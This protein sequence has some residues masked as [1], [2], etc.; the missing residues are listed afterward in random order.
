MKLLV[1][2]CSLSSGYGFPSTYDDSRIWPNLL[3]NK[4]GAE[5]TNVSVPGYDNTG[6]FLNAISEFTAT[7]YDLILVQFTSL[8]RIV[9]S[10]NVHSRLNISNGYPL[11]HI[12]GKKENL[13]FHKSFVMLNKG[14]EHWKRL[15]KIIIT[16][17]NLNKQ[18][19]NIKFING[20]LSWDSEFFSGPLSDSK[21]AKYIIDF[22]E[23][24]DQDI[25]MAFESIDLDRKQLELDLWLNPFDS[26]YQHQIDNAPLDHHP[27]EKSNAMFADLVYNLI[28]TQGKK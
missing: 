17:Q 18:G 6:I 23:L 24:P 22:D 21:F 10:P 25:A 5:L 20:L 7:D 13:E 19:Y 28:T 26:F 14:F 12:L 4:L 8:E 9:I 15:A 16:L 11:D 2:G 3:A 1:S 27:G